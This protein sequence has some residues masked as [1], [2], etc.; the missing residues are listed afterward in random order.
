MDQADSGGPRT[1]GWPDFFC[2]LV[3]FDMLYWHRKDGGGICKIAIEEFD[4]LL[5]Q[6]M[7]LL[8]AFGL[9]MIDHRRSR[10]RSRFALG[11]DG[12]LARVCTDP[13]VSSSTGA[14]VDLGVRDTLADM[15][16]TVAENFGAAIPHGE[17]FLREIHRPSAQTAR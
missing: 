3:D 1:K 15:G 6:F 5:E 7:P 12:S 16:Q 2:N 11:N 10:L 8:R 17:S 4:E 9:L 14:G 13:D